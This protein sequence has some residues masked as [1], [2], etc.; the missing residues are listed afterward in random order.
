[1]TQADRGA[2]PA[3]RYRFLDQPVPLAFAHRGGA[4]HPGNVGL[5]N[6]RQAF[7]RAVDLG[8]RYLETDVHL[9]RDEVLVA[10][11][12]DTLDR[13]TD[14][15]GAVADLPYASVKSARIGGQ[16]P[17]PTLAEL[18]TAWP[19]VRFNIDIKSAAAI[20][21]LCDVLAETAAFDRVCIASFSEAR[22]RR[23]RRLLGPSVA[24]S[25]GPR[26]V[27]VLKLVP[28]HW[29]RRLL[30]PRHVPCVQVPVR[31]G[32]GMV[33][34]RRGG[35]RLV[36]ERFV[37]RAHRHGR[38][39]HVWTVD[40]AESMHRLLD[41]GVD[42]IM[43]DRTDVLRDVLVARGQWHGREPARQTGGGA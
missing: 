2:D 16:E 39:V 38:Q 6:T 15:R 9:T 13:T 32:V 42:G 11:H 35:W 27:A 17:V 23:A 31:F 7:Q 8:Y 37:R 36:T 18:L 24:T 28:G 1:M 30:L 10:F 3:A 33:P 22:M 41:L 5:E 43:T 21:A 26:G 19:D 4:E 20:T 14:G 25:F 29:L 34:G 12:D 40:D